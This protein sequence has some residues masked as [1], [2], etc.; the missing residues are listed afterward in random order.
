VVQESR[1]VKESE[2]AK[3]SEAV[4]ESDKMLAEEVKSLAV[5]LKPE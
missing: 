1:L 4:K 2:V 5:F 3:E